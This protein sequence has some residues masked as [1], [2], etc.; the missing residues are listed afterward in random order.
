MTESL[1]LKQG[2]LAMYAFLDGFYS[3]TKSDDVGGLLGDMSFLADGSTA[4]GAAWS[5]WLEAVRKITEE[6][7]ENYGL[8]RLYKS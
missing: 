2:F 3:R 6:P 1:T 8:L 7:D 5:D 4:D